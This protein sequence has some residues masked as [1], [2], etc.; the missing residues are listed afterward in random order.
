MKN[1]RMFK[2]REL[3]K[4]IKTLI[5]HRQLYFYRNNVTIKERLAYG[6]V[7]CILLILFCQITYSILPKEYIE[8]FCLLFFI[9]DFSVKFFL[10]DIQINILPYLV[11]PFRRESLIKSVLVLELIDVW[12]LYSG[13]IVLFLLV[14]KFFSTIHLNGLVSSVNIYLL[15]VL[16]DY[17]IIAIK[18][19]MNRGIS[20]LL[21]PFFLLLLFPVYLLFFT[22]IWGTIIIIVLIVFMFYCN[23][24][25]LDRK[26]YKQLNE[27]SF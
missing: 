5:N 16:N 18:N 12:N 10:K 20:L 17:C 9:L 27:I 24:Y 25:I 2:K 11:L 4:T 14:V 19:S 15:F 1:N 26:L 23:I 22:R 6:M 13:I 21:M 3:A 7:L 8:L